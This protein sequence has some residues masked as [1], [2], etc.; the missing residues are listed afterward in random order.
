MKRIVTY[1]LLSLFSLAAGAEGLVNM[2]KA[3]LKQLQPR[4]SIL[5]ADQL[6]YGF[7]LEDVKEGTELMFQDYSELSNDTLTLVR[8]WQIDTLRDRRVRKAS[9]PARLRASI[10]LAPFEEGKYRLPDLGVLRRIGD[11]SDTLV[12][13]GLE[14]EVCTIP[15]DTA[16]FVI[17]DIKPQV[18]YPVTPQEV[19]PYVAIFQLIALIAIF[20]VTLIKV[21]RRR[22]E[23]G[24]TGSEPPYIVALRRL[25]TY[26]GD[27]Y[28]APEKQKTLYSGI[29]ETL[30]TYIESRFD[31]NAEEMTTAEIFA[32]LKSSADLTPEMFDELKEL[33]ESWKKLTPQQ[34]EA[35]QNL[36]KSMNT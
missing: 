25:E 28:W 26:R 17:H 36:L 10:V 27:K 9:Q 35:V 33:F 8:N 20:V 11:E 4:D 1:L 5:I 16:D 30:R 24:S 7:E 14:I 23:A 19:A 21:R 12:F 32:G 15:V 22:E 34:K 29:T 13:E 3:Y 18:R 6:E 31:I 2:G